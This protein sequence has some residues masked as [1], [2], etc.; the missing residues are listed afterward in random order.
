MRNILKIS[1]LALSLIAATGANAQAVRTEKNMSL[2]L[3]NQT[4]SAS[5]VACAANGH[6]VSFTLVDMRERTGKTG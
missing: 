3:A 6:A 1:A 4:A 2:E 5:V